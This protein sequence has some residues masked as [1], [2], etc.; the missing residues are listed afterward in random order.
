MEKMFT[1]KTKMKMKQ[2]MCC[3]TRKICRL[4]NERRR[5]RE[6]E[7]VED[8]KKAKG[9]QTGKVLTHF[10]QMPIH[11]G[12]QVPNIQHAPHICQAEQ[13]KLFIY[14]FLLLSCSWCQHH[15]AS[16]KITHTQR[17]RWLRLPFWWFI[18]N[19]SSIAQSHRPDLHN[20]LCSGVD[21]CK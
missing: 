16:W 6:P 2:E 4:P 12:R 14:F 7:R 8:G 1:W 15:C 21:V 10:A 9:E 11:F 18:K 3:A 5:E 19:C 20:K 17:W 13:Q